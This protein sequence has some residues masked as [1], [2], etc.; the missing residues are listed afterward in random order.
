MA[1]AG[2]LGVFLS[3]EPKTVKM[4]LP[5]IDLLGT[6]AANRVRDRE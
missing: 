5:P 4:E 3:D 6:P 1:L 2:L